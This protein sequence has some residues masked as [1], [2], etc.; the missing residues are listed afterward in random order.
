MLINIINVFQAI[1]QIFYPYL[2]TKGSKK[3]REKNLFKVALFTEK[4]PQMNSTISVPTQGIALIKLVITV[5]KSLI[6]LF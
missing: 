1:R 4:P 3:C 2:K 5:A 6:Y